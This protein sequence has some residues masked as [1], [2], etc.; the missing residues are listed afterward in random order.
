MMLRRNI[1]SN[2]RNGSVATAPN[3]P[4]RGLWKK[5]WN[6][7]GLRLGVAYAVGPKADLLVYRSTPRGGKATP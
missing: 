5:D 7:F 3:S 1:F 6:N 2:I 4:L